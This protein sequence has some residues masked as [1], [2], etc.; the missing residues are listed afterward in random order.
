MKRILVM[1]LACV[2][3]GVFALAERE[4]LVV[5]DGTVTLTEPTSIAHLVMTNGVLEMNGFDCKVNRT[6]IGGASTIRNA[7]DTHA[8]LTAWTRRGETAAY[9]CA[10]EGNFTFRRATT[11]EEGKVTC[12]LI[13]MKTVKTSGMYT[14]PNGWIGNTWRLSEIYLMNDGEDVAWPEGASDNRDGVL[15][16]GDP[17]TMTATLTRGGETSLIVDFNGELTFDSFTY[18]TSDYNLRDPADFQ[19]EAGLVSGGTTNWTVIAVLNKGCY[20][21]NGTT[22]N[23]RRYDAELPV[24]WADGYAD[25]LVSI[26]TS[27]LGNRGIEVTGGTLD[28]G[29]SRK[30]TCRQVR[31]TTTKTSGLYTL[32]STDV[33]RKNIANTWRVSEVVLRN[34]GEDVAWPEGTT[35]NLGANAI[36]GDPKTLTSTI[37]RGTSLVINFGTDLTFDSF[38]YGT[39][40]YNYRDP[41]DFILEAGVEE[42]GVM[43]WYPVAMVVKGGYLCGAKDRAYELYEPGFQVDWGLAAPAGQG[44]VLPETYEIAVADKAVV[45]VHASESDL[46]ATRKVTGAGRVDWYGGRMADLTTTA[47]FTGTLAPMT[48]LAG[49]G[50]PALASVEVSDGTLGLASTNNACP[51][52][53]KIGAAGALKTGGITARYLRFSVQKTTLD[54]EG[55]S[56]SVQVSELELLHNGKRVPWPSGTVAEYESTGAAINSNSPAISLVDGL[57]DGSHRIY[58]RGTPVVIES[59]REVLFDGYRLYAGNDWLKRVND[60]GLSRHPVSWTVEYSFDGETWLTFDQVEDNYIIYNKFTQEPYNLNEETNIQS[61]PEYVCAPFYSYEREASTLTIAGQGVAL[62]GT[63]VPNGTTIRLKDGLLSGTAAVAGDAVVSA[64]GGVYDLALDVAGSLNLVR[65]EDAPFTVHVG[66]ALPAR[67]T[68]FTCSTLDD[69]SL[70]VLNALTADDLP[71]G[72]NLRL[73]SR[74]ADNGRTAYGFTA[75]KAGFV[76]LVR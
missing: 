18:G 1:G 14:E 28:V 42:E 73:W 57:A 46:T 16:D 15:I 29:P 62:D 4:E 23:K 64:A 33:N 5:V 58:W 52:W 61:S 72:V 10:L 35:C 19:L 48:G 20:L 37:K 26:R 63:S 54:A 60:A 75:L 27:S 7:S 55:S 41:S 3:S 53:A 21:A 17:T 47:D 6:S 71:K 56:L 9:D 34:G 76:L 66:S 12:N 67:K 65:E 39:S 40:D 69:D 59:P 44:L 74:P 2:S 38:T 8:T 49:D 24:K 32:A 22:K 50:A 30:V 68:L 36:D 25:G 13:R 43:R 11:V 31:L 45:A 70:A 51:V